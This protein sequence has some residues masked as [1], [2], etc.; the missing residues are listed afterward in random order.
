MKT[1]HSQVRPHENEP[2]SGLA[3]RIGSQFAALLLAMMVMP[4]AFQA[5]DT[6]SKPSPSLKPSAAPGVAAD[7]GPTS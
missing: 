5:N 6:H 2:G 3:R 4:S 1:M 7:S